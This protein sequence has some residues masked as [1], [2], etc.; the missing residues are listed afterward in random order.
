MT[1]RRPARPAGR[2]EKNNDRIRIRN[3]RYKIKRYLA[4]PKN[5]D[6]KLNGRVVRRMV[7]RRQTIYP[8]TRRRREY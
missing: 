4:Q 6:V 2:G 7:V 5:V 3:R 8:I 1:P